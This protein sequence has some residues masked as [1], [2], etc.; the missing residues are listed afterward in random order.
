MNEFRQERINMIV[1]MTMQI[2]GLP[3]HRVQKIVEATD[4]YRDILSGEENVLYDGYSANLLD[5]VEEWKA[6]DDIPIKAKN[7]TVEKIDFCNK[8][9]KKHKIENSR[10]A[11]VLLEKIRNSRAKRGKIRFIGRVG[12]HRISALK[13]EAIREDKMRKNSVNMK[14]HVK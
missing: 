14:A 5:M 7:I 3:Q 8:W 4:V 2:T 12:T 1:A 11:I 6:K 13:R 10:Q 9:M